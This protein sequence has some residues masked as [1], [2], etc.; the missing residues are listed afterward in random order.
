[1]TGLV[2]KLLICFEP[3]TLQN[4]RDKRNENWNRFSSTVIYTAVHYS[5]RLST[6][7]YMLRD[8]VHLN[9]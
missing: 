6:V 8:R 9:S 2:E 3:E 7:C 4:R 5:R 1:M